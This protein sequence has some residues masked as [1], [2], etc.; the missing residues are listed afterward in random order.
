VRGAQRTGFL[1]G[2]KKALVEFITVQKEDKT[3]EKV[4]NP[5]Y[6]T[7]LTQDQQ[8]MSYLNSTLSKEVLGQVTSCETPEEVWAL[9]HGMYASQS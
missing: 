8:L 2:T 4:L 6:I 3:E 1:D 5:E 9:V 7:W